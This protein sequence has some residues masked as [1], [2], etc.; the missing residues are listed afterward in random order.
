MP[1]VKKSLSQAKEV[2]I[3]IMKLVDDYKKNFKS[4]NTDSRLISD[5]I[6]KLKNLYDSGIITIEEFEA[7]KKQFFGL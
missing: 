2:W 5:E 7:G 6:I 3:C 1:V 4:Q